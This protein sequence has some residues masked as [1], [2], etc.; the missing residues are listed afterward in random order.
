M[1]R[2]PPVWAG[3]T[4]PISFTTTLHW[5]R[6]ELN[7]MSERSEFPAADTLELPPQNQEA[8][9]TAPATGKKKKKRKKKRY[10]LKFF[11]FCLLC[12]GGYYFLTSEY[13]N[14]TT[15]DVGGTVLH[16]AQLIR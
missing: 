8:F 13:F 12:T 6:S 5:I 3:P 15:I 1:S 14:I 9:Y 11:I 7:H 2:P 16:P 10:L 4:P